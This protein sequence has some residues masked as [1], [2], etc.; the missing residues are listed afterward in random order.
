MKRLLCV[1]LCAYAVA[2]FGDGQATQI[3]I[4]DVTI[5]QSGS[6]RLVNV[7]Y[8]LGE[9]PAIVTVDFLTNGVS[10]GEGNFNNVFGAVNRM[11]VQTQ[12]V[13][14]IYWK[15]SAS[16]AGN[17]GVEISAKVTAWEQTD[18]P[19]YMVVSLKD[20]S[21]APISY[22][23]ST[24]AFPHGF[25]NDI[26]RTSRLV[27]RRI[28]AAGIKWRMGETEE[29]FVGAQKN[30]DNVYRSNAKAHN[31]TLSQDYF[32][33]VY[34]I[35]QEQYRHFR[36]AILL[37]GAFTGYADSPM[38]PRTQLN[39]EDLR[40]SGTG[41]D[42]AVKKDSILYSL[43]KETG[44]EFDLP[45]EAQWEFACKA[46]EPGLLYSGLALTSANISKIAWIYG[47][48]LYADINERQTHA[49]GQKLPNKW[50]LYDMI[51]NTLEWCLDTYVADLGEDDV[52]DPIMSTGSERVLRGSRYDR[53][54]TPY[55]RSTYRGHDIE[56]RTYSQANAYGFRVVCALGLKFSQPE[57]DDDGGSETEGE[58]ETVPQE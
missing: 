54:W 22:Y 53:T 47:N 6:T 4:S 52:V 26:Y 45:T 18:P 57:P 13:H 23:V 25:S 5:S 28:H 20:P 56:D 58:E 30:S 11:V 38:R 48:S 19:D 16:W 33:G 15:P 39:F 32:I 24:N 55:H 31:V 21:V 12:T 51:G 2:A 49:V 34:P 50:G 37:G 7:S 41:V 42:H 43:R 27:M 10:I 8:R 17:S 40:G 1:L 46:G 14:S 29:D 9:K 44:I 3:T 35:T 36:N